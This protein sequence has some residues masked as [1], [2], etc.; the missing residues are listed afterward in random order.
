MVRDQGRL[1]PCTGQTGLIGINGSGISQ[2]DS[3][4]KIRFGTSN[5]IFSAAGIQR[6]R[7]RTWMLSATDMDMG[8]TYAFHG[9]SGAKFFP[10]LRRCPA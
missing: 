9:R 4:K 1:G 5:L 7:R 10:G 3:I 8:M 6:Y 2:S